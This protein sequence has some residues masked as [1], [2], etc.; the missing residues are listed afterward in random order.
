MHQGLRKIAPIRQK[1]QTIALEEFVAE[2]PSPVL[3]GRWIIAGGLGR[4]AGGGTVEHL[5][6]DLIQGKV[7]DSRMM[8]NRPLWQEL[9]VPLLKSEHTVSDAPITIGRTTENDVFINDYTVSRN[10]AHFFID[11]QTRSYCLVDNHSRNGT[12]I[13]GE[14]LEPAEPTKLFSGHMVDVG[15]LAFDFYSAIDFYHYLNDTDAPQLIPKVPNWFA[16]QEK[17][18]IDSIG[19]E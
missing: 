10:H 12:G 17:E 15:R 11:P 5:H 4:G 3:V 19:Y 14:R 8:E 2:C 7:S 18:L 9:Y 6:L 16:K 13:Q 1:A